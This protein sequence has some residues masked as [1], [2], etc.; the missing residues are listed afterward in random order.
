MRRRMLVILIL[1][2]LST[3]CASNAPTATEIR[4]AVSAAAET[5][6]GDSFDPILCARRYGWDGFWDEVG[7]C[8]Y[9]RDEQFFVWIMQSDEGSG[10]PY[11][12]LLISYFDDKTEVRF[13]GEPDWFIKNEDPVSREL[14]ALFE[15]VIARLNEGGGRD[16]V[17]EELQKAQLSSLSSESAP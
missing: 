8:A 2:M 7:Y 3:A 6:E 11:D 15:Q 12:T 14:C 17:E 16:A 10:K 9:D 1:A 13:S 4:D 5:D